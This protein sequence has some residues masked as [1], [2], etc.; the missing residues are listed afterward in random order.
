M[1]GKELNYY[2]GGNT[3]KGFYGVFES[4]MQGL[5]RVFILKG[6]PGTGK[7]TLLKKLGEAWKEKG[8]D[9]ERIHCSSDNNSLDGLIIPALK[10]GMFD[11]TA[12]HVLEPSVPGAIEE[13][14]NL[15][16]AWDSNRL[17]EQKDVIQKYQEKISDAFQAAYDSFATGL[18]VHDELE[19]IYISNMDFEKADD[20]TRNLIERL[21]QDN[22]V[23]GKNA[24]VKHRFFGA[25]TPEGS[26]DFIPNITENIK[27][28][29]FIKGRAGTGKSTLLKKIA[30]AAEERGF[31]VEVYHCG[32]DPESLDMVI[33]RELDFCLFDS[34][35]PH[36]YFPDRPSDEVID[37]YELTVNSGTD[38]KFEKD[39][40]QLTDE[41][42][43]FMKK[44]TSYLQEAKR[45]HDKLENIYVDS[46]DFSITDTIYEEISGELEQ[47][48]A[49]VG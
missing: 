21:Y 41:Y 9:I 19:E 45:L 29:F 31:D 28:R 44:G 10:F 7:S 3:A 34:T 43:S 18:R 38:E 33:V 37:L 1:A 47:L 40:K 20:V 46:I 16:V 5:E 22:K 32:F 24:N 15:G 25:A 30:A 6:G 42:K 13:Y 14:V 48:E 27:K 8:Y 26:V 12:P 35:D 36:E 17:A 2:A 39:I 11:G 4:N 23:V 49:I